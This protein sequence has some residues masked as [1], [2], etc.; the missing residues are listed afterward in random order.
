MRLVYLVLLAGRH[1]LHRTLPETRVLLGVMVV[2]VGIVHIAVLVAHLC[3]PTSRPALVV[4]V[5]KERE[6]QQ[7]NQCQR[8]VV[9]RTFLF[10]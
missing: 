5:G 3:H 6:Q 1:F 9:G 4:M 8:Y 7:N 10:H 2:C